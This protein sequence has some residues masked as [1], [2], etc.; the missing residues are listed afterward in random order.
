MHSSVSKASNPGVSAECLV[1]HTA[2]VRAIARAILSRE[3]LA[4]DAV[5]DAFTVALRSQ[6]RERGR[7]R[8]WLGGI[9]RRKAL[10]IRRQEARR[11]AREGLVRPGTLCLEP[12]ALAMRA[13]LG[14]RLISH[15]LELPEPYRH[16]LLLRF[17]SGLSIRA[18][19]TTLD[20]PVETVRTR[21]RR[22]LARLRRV[23]ADRDRMNW[24]AALLPLALDGAGAGLAGVVA[25][26]G[27]LIMAKKIMAG[28]GIILLLAGGVY[29]GGSALDVWPSEG[30]PALPEAGAGLASTEL[31]G[32]ESGV[33]ELS[34]SESP[35]RPTP[36]GEPSTSAPQGRYQGTLLDPQGR[37]V[38]GVTL[39]VVKTLMSQVEADGLPRVTPD[40]EGRFAF[41][42]P[43]S[44]YQ[45]QVRIHSDTHVPNWGGRIQTIWPSRPAAIVMVRAVELRV[46]VKDGATGLPVEGARVGAYAQL[47]RSPDA[48]A[49]MNPRDERRTDATGHVTVRTR[50]GRGLL[51]VRA[52]GYRAAM[53]ADLDVPADGG[54]RTVEIGRGGTVNG[55]IVDESGAP[56]PGVRISVRGFPPYEA[57]VETDR[58]GRFV[59]RNT[60]LSIDPPEPVLRYHLRL[61]SQLPG[62]GVA[63]HLRV[64]PPDTPG[65]EVDVTLTWYDER[66]LR[67]RVLYADGEPAE[68]YIVTVAPHRD[69]VGNRAAE[70][71]R[72]DRSG[73]FVTPKC[74]PGRLR[75]QARR[76]R[77]SGEVLAESTVVLPTTGASPDVELRLRVKAAAGPTLVVRVRTHAGASVDAG[78]LHWSAPSGRGIRGRSAGIKKDGTTLSEGVRPRLE[79]WA[80]VPGYVPYVVRT[81]E[82]DIAAGEL[83]MTL[84]A[85][86]AG[87]RVVREDGSPASIELTAILRRVGGAQ[88]GRRLFGRAKIKT[89]E[90]GRFELSGLGDARYE[91]KPSGLE[92]RA[93]GGYTEIRAGR[94]DAEIVVGT[95]AELRDRF[96]EAVLIDGETGKPLE[97]WVLQ[98]RLVE[99]GAPADADPVATL[100]QITGSK[101]VFRTN[102]AVADGEYD[103]VIPAVFGRR[104]ARA[105]GVRV[106]AG[107]PRE[108]V[109]LTW[110]RGLSVAG[111]VVDAEGTPAQGVT[112]AAGGHSANVGK[113]GTYRVSGLA[114]GLV[115]VKVTGPYVEERTEQ[116]HV[117][118][119][120]GGTLDLRVETWGAIRVL[121]ASAFGPVRQVHITARPDGAGAPVTLQL[122]ADEYDKYKA[123]YR[124]IVLPRLAPG[125]WQVDVEWDGKS[126]ASETVDVRPCQTSE[127]QLAAN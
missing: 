37:P 18:V 105:T 1:E 76:D 88:D 61:W 104:E 44:K 62:E 3:D 57:K 42:V 103:V 36:G 71:V 87:G 21:Q 91:L 46:R 97:G 43:G 116:V 82:A 15:V 41:D 70:P 94:N 65:G 68:G 40:G 101:S 73:R 50:P 79:I 74:L 39:E 27:G 127:V 92:Y 8:A 22:A 11:R 31:P 124:E 114:A 108:R 109:T 47:T 45:I 9:T 85:G 98:L 119:E 84:P 38:P 35:G 86:R 34:P 78:T 49:H 75:V 19:A 63:R 58:D 60:P 121:P 100:Q 52:E 23:L 55:R 120:D 59:L 24:R 48:L 72:T 102:R 33:P 51:L 117:R 96:V 126:V 25:T 53:Q 106:G 81:T 69:F 99:S 6:P 110:R 26:T 20:I 107:A 111:R 54:S 32:D 90:Q 17:Q 122:S 56:K 4:D 93:I 16:V 2:F 30:E 112:V 64:T 125:R 66:P 13:D 113:D 10:E 67:G 12:D 5:Q 118:E 89:D 77:P 80:D 14:R 123:A 95:E 83:E 7:L 29:W 115:D 28:V